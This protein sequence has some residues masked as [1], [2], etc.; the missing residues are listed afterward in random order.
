MGSTEAEFQAI[1]PSA[2][3]HLPP[4][5]MN[6]RK[7]AFVVML[8]FPL[9]QVGIFRFSLFSG[10]KQNQGAIIGLA[11][12]NQN[13]QSR[14]NA[15]SGAH[16]Y[17]DDSKKKEGSKLMAKKSRD[18][19]CFLMRQKR[20][21]PRLASFQSFGQ[22]TNSPGEA[23]FF[24]EWSSPPIAVFSCTRQKHSAGSTGKR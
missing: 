3:F 16:V 12:R 6:R 15:A 14:C 20:L 9:K 19:F 17:R 18:H 8:P 22:P 7:F 1:A 5:D 24:P 4:Y 11:A 10:R 2:V 23:K 21:N 13:R